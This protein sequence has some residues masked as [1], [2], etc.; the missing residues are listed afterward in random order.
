MNGFSLV[1]RFDGE[2]SDATRSL[3]AKHRKKLFASA[4]GTSRTGPYSLL[5][6]SVKIDTRRRRA[7]EL[8]HRYPET[9]FG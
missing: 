8:Q 9:L 1:A 6:R 5:L 7:H 2:F 4:P 3:A